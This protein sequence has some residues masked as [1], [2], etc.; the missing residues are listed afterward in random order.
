MARPP[1]DLDFSTDV[2][3]SWF[4]RESDTPYSLVRVPDESAAEWTEALGVTVRR[5]YVSDTLLVARAKEL[6]RPASEILAARLPDPG[7][8][9]SGDFGEILVYLFLACEAGPLVAVGPK[10][11]RLK[12]DRTKPAPGSDV[13]HFVLPDWPLAGANDRLLCA[14]VKAKATRG[15]SKPIAAAIRDSEKDRTSRLARTLIWLRERALFEDLGDVDL[16]ELDR[17]IEADKHPAFEKEYKA[18]AVVCTSL[19]E[20][21][22]MDAPAEEP[23]SYSVV[24]IAVPDLKAAYT[25]VYEVARTTTPSNREDEELSQ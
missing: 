4:E 21:E 14:E 15:V 13:I 6:G 8:T 9:M 3:A 7:S 17:F 11:W 19:L 20:D 16:E 22:L 1:D 18:I 23:A 12:Q 24:V 25:R 2:V 10:K 5:C